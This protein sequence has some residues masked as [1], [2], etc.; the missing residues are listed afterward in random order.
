MSKHRLPVALCLLA[1]TAFAQNGS[2][3]AAVDSAQVARTAWAAGVRALRANDLATARREV[4]HAASAWPSQQAYVWGRAVMAARAGDTTAVRVALEDYAKLGLGRDLRSDSVFAAFRAFPWFADVAR[5]HDANRA[6]VANSTIRTTIADS[7]FWPEGVDYD[8]HTKRFYVASIRHRTITEI[9][10]TGRTRE[11][12]PVNQRNRGAVMGVRV[13]PRGGVL[14]ATMA[15]LPQMEGFVPSD[16]G[17]AALVRVNIRSGAIERQWNLP[18]GTKHVPGDLAI[19]PRGDVFVTDSDQ[20]VL[21]RLRIAAD[22]LESVTSPLFRSLQGMAPSPDGRWLFLADYSH[23]L[24]RVDL[25]THAV[26]RVADAPNSTA[27]GCDGIVW[28]RGSIIAVQNG[29]VPA[30]V[31]RFHLDARGERVTRAELLDRNWPIADEPTI[32]TL[33]GDT[34]V[35][36]ADSQWEKYSDDGKRKAEVKLTSPVLL[37]IDL[38]N[39]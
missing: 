21:Y 15:G 38:R 39:R 10:R 16:S 37:S 28:Y 22:T 18:G 17:I 32:G 13:D 4:E 27:L 19:G 9:L 36:V 6:V 2:G 7:T 26:T 30:R 3:I 20:P 33:A 14:W 34:F 35:Y 11:L 1:A 8:A 23:G 29:V 25:A 24:L 5:E 12:W 31:M